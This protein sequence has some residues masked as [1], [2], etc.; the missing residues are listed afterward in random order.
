VLETGLAVVYC[1]PF[2][3]PPRDDGTEAR[4]LVDSLAPES[5]LHA[6]LFEVRNKLY[7]HTDEEYAHRREAVDPFGAHSYAEAYRLLNPD[8]L[9]PIELLALALAERFREQRKVLE[10]TLRDAGVPAEP[11]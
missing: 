3:G 9:Q 10:Q 7:A 11:S 8:L 1:R 6:K 2:S 4:T 5:H